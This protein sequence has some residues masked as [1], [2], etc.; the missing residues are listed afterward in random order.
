MYVKDQ[1]NNKPYC[2]TK[3]TSISK[4]LEIMSMHNFHRL[5][6]VDKDNNLVGLITEG[7]I[8]EATTGKATSLSIYEIN[9]LLNKSNVGD[10]MIKDVVTIDPDALLEEAAVKMRTNDIGC[11]V[12]CRDNKVTGIIT[13]NDIFRAFIDLLGYNRK[14]TR[15]VINVKED[16]VG[17]LA[18]VAMLF[19]QLDINITNLAVYNTSRGIEV[20]VIATGDKCNEAAKALTDSGY[21]LTDV[22][23]KEEGTN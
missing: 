14:G 13:Q 22:L 10:I 16:K 21:N 19:K 1:M 8:S 23:T 7:L 17:I 2:V 12:A 5:P 9:Y 11:L 18:D 6:V 15:Y 4:A 20:V 3:E